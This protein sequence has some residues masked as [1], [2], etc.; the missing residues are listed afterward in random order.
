MSGDVPYPSNVLVERVAR[1]ETRQDHT[2]VA[3][4]SLTTTVA[5]HSEQFTGVRE[6]VHDLK[7]SINRLLY[8]VWGLVLVLL[9]IAAEIIKKAGS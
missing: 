5:V 8:G 7:R 6:D 2:D 1:V 4:A 9:P 3:V